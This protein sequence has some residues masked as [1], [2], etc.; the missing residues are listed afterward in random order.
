MRSFVFLAAMAL[1]LP[2]C[3]ASRKYKEALAREQ[4]L[5]EQNARLTTNLAELNGNLSSLNARLSDAQNENARLIGQ[6]DAAGKNAAEL[7]QLA[8]KTQEQLAQEQQRLR[9]NQQRLERMQQL[10]DQQRQAIEGLRQNMTKALVNFKPEEL[11]VS[12]KN[13]KVYVSLQESLLFPSG[14]AEVNP[15]GKEA[16]GKLAAALNTNPDISVMIEGHTDSIPIRG[17]YED[18]WALSTARSASIVRILTGA[19]RVD[20]VRVTASGR[21][22][23]EPVE[24]NATPEGRARN[25]RTEIILS[26]KLDELMRLLEQAPTTGQ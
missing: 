1:T 19:Y 6:V 7:G 9:E 13:G 14:S 26:P 15:R 24:S 4:T 18:N 25:R 3:V 21:S 17:R 10:M 16:L 23:Y 22:Q 20:P 11:T 5:A 12:I 8:N 2:S